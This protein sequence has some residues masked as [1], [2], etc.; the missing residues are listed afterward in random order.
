MNHQSSIIAVTVAE[1]RLGLGRGTR[2][3]GH[4]VLRPASTARVA[5]YATV[6]SGTSFSPSP[7]ISSTA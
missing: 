6:S 5:R 4:L 3:L 2:S 7:F 1:K